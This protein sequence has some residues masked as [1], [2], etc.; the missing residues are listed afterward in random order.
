MIRYLLFDLDNTL[1]SSR[2]GLQKDVGHRIWEQTAA[3]LGVT[4]DEARQLRTTWAQFG[5]NLEWLI[6]EKGFSDCEAYLA[7]IHPPDEADTLP[8]DPGLRA[9]LSGIALPKAILTNAPSEHADLILGK[10]GISDLFTRI[11]DVRLITNNGQCTYKGKP[12][13]EFY[14]RALNAL[15]LRAE[16]SLFIDD[17]P[18]NVEAFIALG[19]RALL[20]DEND[21]HADSPLPRIRDLRELTQYL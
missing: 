12:E 21:K 9:F 17:F 5:T 10:L 4:P 1:Y 11:F 15:E 3:F 13:P 7:A 20:F 8:P 6:A 2:F 16:E 18:V 14:I 19:G